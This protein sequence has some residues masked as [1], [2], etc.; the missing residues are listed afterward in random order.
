MA[1]TRT[2]DR[3]PQTRRCPAGAAPQTPAEDNGARTD[4][5]SHAVYVV[6]VEGSDALW[7]KIGGA[8]LHGDRQGFNIVLSAVVSG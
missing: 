3:K 8:W 7:T 4:L 6:K 1:T 5:P 2:S